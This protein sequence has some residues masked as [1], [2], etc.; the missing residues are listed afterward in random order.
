KTLFCRTEVVLRGEI[1]GKRRAVH[2]WV[3][4]AHD[5]SSAWG[6]A[7]RAFPAGATAISTCR[8][9]ASTTTVDGAGI[10]TAAAAVLKE[11]TVSFAPEVTVLYTYARE[12]YPGR[13][14]DQPAPFTFND[15][16]ELLQLRSAY[17]K[18]TERLEAERAALEAERAAPEAARQLPQASRE[19]REAP[20]EAEAEEDEDEE[21]E[22]DDEEEDDE[23][24][25]EEE[26]GEE[27]L[28]AEAAL[29]R[30]EDEDAPAASADEFFPPRRRR[31]S[32]PALTSRDASGAGAAPR[33]SGAPPAATGVPRGA[34]P[35]RPAGIRGGKQGPPRRRGAGYSDRGR[36][37]PGFAPSNY[38]PD[39]SPAAGAAPR[40]P[41]SPAAAAKAAR[42][43]PSPPV[44]SSGERR[45]SQRPDDSSPLDHG[46]HRARA[47]RG[48]F[49]RARGGRLTLKHV[50]PGDCKMLPVVAH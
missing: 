28:E 40:F 45:G 25:E 47:S 43:R 11:R 8:P 24:E 37:P 22:V 12:D 33:A 49:R 26:D 27:G 44:P 32:R 34:A 18:A 41:R 9:G 21:D 36:R 16:L 23:Q 1:H 29:R 46:Q 14:P 10:S 42:G 15:A 4:V 38:P 6:S 13:A 35:R 30:A 3:R 20:P 7:Y 17:R 48:L 31:S 5:G 50:P 2:V 19:R 39:L